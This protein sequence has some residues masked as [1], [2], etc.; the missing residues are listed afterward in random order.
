MLFEYREIR[1]PTQVAEILLPTHHPC[2]VI[3][4]ETWVTIGQRESAQSFIGSSALIV[5]RDGPAGNLIAGHFVYPDVSRRTFAAMLEHAKKA[6]PDI[7]SARVD[8][9]GVGELADPFARENYD[10][11][12]ETRRYILG[13]LDRAG[14]KN[15]GE[16]W[17]TNGQWQ[18]VLI[19]GDDRSVQY[20]QYY[21]D[22]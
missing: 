2:G 6:I 3:E 17:A 7:R 15:V 10:H 12:L 13:E 20:R 8:C 11:V 16:H 18:D 1:E 5:I 14:F 4:F 19:R 9:F 22:S 21:P